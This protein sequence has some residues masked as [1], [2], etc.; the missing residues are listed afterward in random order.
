MMNYLHNTSGMR[1][2]N[3]HAKK[4]IQINNVYVIKMIDKYLL[5]KL[6]AI[7]FRQ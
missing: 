5:L 2:S 6:F 4:E 7:F 3:L 1:K